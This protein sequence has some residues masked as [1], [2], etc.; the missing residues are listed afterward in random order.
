M[1][2]SVVLPNRRGT[3]PGYLVED[4]GKTIVLLPGVPW[5]MKALFAESVKAPEP[6]LAPE[7]TPSATGIASPVALRLPASNGCASSV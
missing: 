7:P 3:A 5:E 2:R 6:V 1:F 4:D